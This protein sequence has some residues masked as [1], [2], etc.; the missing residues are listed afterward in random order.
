[1]LIKLIRN[2]LLIGS[3]TMI[4]SCSSSQEQQGEE[5]SL[6]QQ[7]EGEAPAEEYSEEAPSEEYSEGGADYEDTANAGNVYSEEMGDYAENSLNALVADDSAD[8]MNNLTENSMDETS[9]NAMNEAPMNEA[10][11][12]EAPMNDATSYAATGSRT[13]MY[14]TGDMVSVFSSP[15]QASGQVGTLNAGDPVLA[16]VAGSFAKIGEARYV[17]IESLTNE[18]VGRTRTPNPWR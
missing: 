18:V 9:L 17:S 6:E 15:D 3:V 11:M 7:A 5:L 8:S 2:G 14:V 10:P 1:M 16:E 13:V 12:N 4:F